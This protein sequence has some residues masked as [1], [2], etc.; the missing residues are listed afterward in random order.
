M[1]RSDRPSGNGQDPPAAMV[2]RRAKGSVN[3]ALRIGSRY[4]SGHGLMLGPLLYLDSPPHVFADRNPDGF[5]L[6]LDIDVVGSAR[7]MNGS[8]H[9]M[10]ASLADSLLYG[11]YHGTESSDGENLACWHGTAV[12]IGRGPVARTAC[13]CIPLLDG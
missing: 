12:R 7:D 1:M 11:P 2:E 10:C 3:S 6:S 13:V 4:P 5:V 8:C 9:R